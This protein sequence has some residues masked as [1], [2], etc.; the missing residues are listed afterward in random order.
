VNKAK[1]AY[2][3]RYKVEE[4]G[5]PACVILLALLAFSIS[6]A[7][8]AGD[9]SLIVESANPK[10]LLTNQFIRRNGWTGADGA[11]SIP[12][13]NDRTIWFFGDTWI[14]KIRGGR[15]VDS[16]MINN[17]VAV[18]NTRDQ[19]QPLQFFWRM[20]DDK[21]AAVFAS[22][23]PNEWFWPGDGIT[24]DGKLF[25][26]LHRVRRTNSSSAWGFEPAGE[27]L[28][29][30]ESPLDEPPSWKYC[31]VPL[32][33]QFRWGTAVATDDQYVYAYCEYPSAEQ[34]W[35]KHP[36]VLAR[37]EKDKLKK[38]DDNGWQYWCH[39]ST[40]PD[41]GVWRDQPTDPIVLIPDGAPEMTVSRVPGLPGYFATYTP[42]GIGND[43]AIRHADRP[44]G[45]WSDPQVVYRCPAA[46]GVSK[47]F[48]YGAKAHPELAK[49]PGELVITYCQNS[50]SLQ[51]N[52][53]HPQ[54]Y[55][56]HGMSVIL[57]CRH[58]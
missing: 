36:T 37:I 2:D 58:P 26:F 1:R 17:T 20:T 3:R 47:V 52:V 14:G 39:S 33:A 15:R 57:R 34:Q 46:H 18:E 5:L 6:A 35:F 27:I 56:P 55:I 25:V 10:P 29:C 7:A 54:L 9:Q 51:D 38:L 50:E 45:P 31:Q 44:E 22:N 48:T 28:V 30:V 16:T 11:Y 19:L 13:G 43:I 23:R 12:I 42:A 53:D 21:P 24:V 49:K 32:A 8:A 41:S 40:N 4:R